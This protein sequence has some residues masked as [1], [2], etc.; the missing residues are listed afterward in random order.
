[1]RGSW[2]WSLKTVGPQI[3]P[4][5]HKW[6]ST[7]R[8]KQLQQGLQSYGLEVRARPVVKGAK[9]D[10]DAATR[11]RRLARGLRQP[12][13]ADRATRLDL[14]AVNATELCPNL[15]RPPRARGVDL[16]Q[17]SAR[18]PPA[19]RPHRKPSAPAGP[20]NLYHFLEQRP[21]RR[22]RHG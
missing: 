11:G 12:E 17:M 20:T 8:L 15:E 6:T 19:A 13:R 5:N 22:G 14:D 3:G 9:E 21:R 16:S 7:S 2:Q 10:T 4:H 18:A 1:M